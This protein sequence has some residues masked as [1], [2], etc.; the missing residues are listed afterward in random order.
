MAEEQR[1]A[2]GEGR[3]LIIQ[4]RIQLL[5][6]LFIQIRTE[7]PSD[8]ESYLGVNFSRRWWRSSGEDR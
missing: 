5:I 6:Q 3:D 4:P 7:R 8:R 2:P 1:C